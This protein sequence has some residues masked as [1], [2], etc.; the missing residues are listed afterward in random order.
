MNFKVYDMFWPPADSGE[1]FELYVRKSP[2][3]ELTREGEKGLRLDSGNAAR[4]S[5]SFDTWYNALAA[6][7]WKKYAVLNGLYL[8]LR[9]RGAGKVEIFSVS[10]NNAEQ[11][12]LE[13]DFSF[14][15]FEDLRIPFPE[16][17][18][19]LA[20]WRIRTRCCQ[21]QEARYETGSPEEGLNPVY[22]S[23]VI[24]TFKREAYV[25]AAME[26]VE[27][28]MRRDPVLRK[29]LRLRIIDNGNTL[30]AG[31]YAG[32]QIFLYPNLNSGGSGGFARGMLETLADE[33][34]PSTHVLLMDDDIELPEGVLY[35][36]RALLGLLRPEYAG[37]C[38]G[39]TML[40][41]EER[42]ILLASLEY[43]DG[44]YLR[45]RHFPGGRDLLRRCNLARHE[46]T[47][48]NVNQ[49]QGWWYCVIPVT[50]IKEKGLPF[51]FFFQLDDVEY[52]M[53]TQRPILQM[54]GIFVWHE[55][56]NLK[57]ENA[58]YLF[59]FRNYLILSELYPD[60]RRAVYLR[61]AMIVIFHALCFN[62]RIFGALRAALGFFLQGPEH[63]R[64]PK[65]YA[66]LLNEARRHNEEVTDVSLQAARA[67]RSRITPL[68]K[69]FCVLTLNGHLLPAFCLKD[70][71]L[72]GQDSKVR[73]LSNFYLK[74]KLCLVQGKLPLGVLRQRSLPTL[75]RELGATVPL[76]PRFLLR[77]SRVGKLYRNTY[78]EMTSQDFMRRHLGKGCPRPG[79]TAETNRSL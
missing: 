60:R 59:I 46:T 3:A 63:L 56:F 62:Y 30:E 32:E 41:M 16:S 52:A 61:I 51:P 31:A 39:G 70:C 35:K 79:Y 28:A 68:R 37:A 65:I 44:K 5:L 74:K 13:R 54:N 2:N 38:V 26:A 64:D 19:P 71:G 47:S 29:H 4:A 8:H 69:A 50:V 23:I 45:R 10:E 20:A 73:E 76:L 58:K 36:T 75:L 77:R 25:R 57:E 40:N 49:Y 42:H 21:I 22:I 72:M 18:A 34:F 14:Q 12:L 78:G 27:L 7:K 55:N 24:C 11:L 67:S 6:A 15:N 53:R 66:E 33:S 43:H 1:S 48:D 17:D 9:L